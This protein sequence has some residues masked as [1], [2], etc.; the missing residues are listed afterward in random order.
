VSAARAVL[1]VVLPGHVTGSTAVD[2]APQAGAPSPLPRVTR[3][4]CPACSF[5]AASKAALARHC[6]ANHARHNCE[7]CASSFATEVEL[8]V[9]TCD[10]HAVSLSCAICAAKISA[11]MQIG[12]AGGELCEI[13]A[14]VH[15][16]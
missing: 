2:R 10:A 4:V 14:V 13:C 9:H 11:G 16:M 8:F 6:E 5:K 15:E 7:Q 1:G 3:F 12:F